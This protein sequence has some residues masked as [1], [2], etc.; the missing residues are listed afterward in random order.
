M[1]ATPPIAPNNI[2]HKMRYIVDTEDVN[3]TSKELLKK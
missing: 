1:P 3:P 2:E